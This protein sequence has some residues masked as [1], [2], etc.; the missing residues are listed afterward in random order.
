MKKTEILTLALTAGV[1]VAIVW[2]VVA[3]PLFHRGRNRGQVVAL[4]EKLQPGMT[5]QQAQHVIDS[6][7]YPNL[8]SA[9]VD[10]VNRDRWYVSSPLEFGATNWILWVEFS[11]G[12]VSALRIR[13]PDGDW[14]HPPEARPDKTVAPVSTS[15]GMR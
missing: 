5:K 6:G 7:E 12:R 1:V 11:A 2:S 14:D 9:P 3:E 8:R 4:Y 13:T 15:S 10:E